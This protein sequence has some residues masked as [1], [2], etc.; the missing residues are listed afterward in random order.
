MNEGDFSQEHEAFMLSVALKNRQATKPATLQEINKCHS[1]EEP[2]TTG[3]FCDSDCRDD[4]DARTA[5]A[6]RRG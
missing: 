4:Y 6:R 1:C 3:L 2:L 5:A